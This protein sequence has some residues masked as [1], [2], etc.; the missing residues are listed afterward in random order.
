MDAYFATEDDEIV[1]IDRE[2]GKWIY[3]SHSLSVEVEQIID[4]EHTLVY[5]VADI[6]YRDGET[7]TSGFKKPGVPK[8][9]GDMPYM[10]SRINQSIV[11]INSDFFTANDLEHKGILIREGKKYLDN[12]AEDTLVCWPDGSLGIISPGEYTAAELLDMGVQNTWSFGPTLVRDGKINENVEK[13]R[14]SKRKNPRSAIGMAENGHVIL[15]MVEGRQK[16]RSVGV[17]CTE[18]AQMFLDRG[19]ELAY[20]LDGGASAAIVFMGE[21]LN[22]SAK[23]RRVSD[24]LQ[25]GR[26]GLVPSV[27]DPVENQGE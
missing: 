10:L 6:R 19:C 12:K 7:F 13:H 14:I 25:I 9:R 18:L 3:K 4:T 20:N 27:D 8:G 5:F 15:M 26:S 11:G 17:T 2:K 24:I 23:D 16:N 22:K 1:S 21:T